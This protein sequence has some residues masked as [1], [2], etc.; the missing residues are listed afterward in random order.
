MFW[1]GLGPGVRSGRLLPP[2]GSG[3]GL[4]GIRNRSAESSCKR[5][6]GHIIEGSAERRNRDGGRSRE[7]FDF[8]ACRDTWLR[9]A[10]FSLAENEAQ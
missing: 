8:D 4:V 10:V 5:P 1:D 9:F 7:P 2:L 6:R 3:F